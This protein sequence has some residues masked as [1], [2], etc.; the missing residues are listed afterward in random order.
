MKYLETSGNVI[1]VNSISQL[2][3]GTMRMTGDK[4][5]GIRA[6]H[7]AL[8][9]GINFLNTGDFYSAGL[10]ELMVGEALKGRKRDEAF[11]SVKFGALQTVDGRLGVG[12]DLRPEAIE[13]Y[14]VYSLKRLGLEYIDLYQPGRINPHIPVEETIGAI[15]NLV[16]KG[17]VRT[18]GI[19]EVNAEILRRAHITHPISLVEVTY[20]L[21]NRRIEDEL[22]PAARELGVGI[23]AFGVLLAGA[24]GGRSPEQALKMIS[25]MVSSSTLENVNQNMAQTDALKQIADEKGLTLAQLAISWVLSQGYDIMALV[26]SRTVEQVEASLKAAELRLSAADLEKIENIIPKEEALSNYMPSPKFDK[27]GLFKK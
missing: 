18:I 7:A 9:S 13:N 19:T 25:H 4:Q 15:A 2:G 17:Y 8:D 6:I 14:L 11:V 3:L 5:E 12:I 1:P 22:I 23:V 24:I 26:G 16:K 27:N 21:M 10:N 20:S